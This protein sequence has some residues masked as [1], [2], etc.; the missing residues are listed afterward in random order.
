M[1][2]FSFK[3]PTEIIFG[4][5]AEERVAEKIR[6]YGGSRVFIIYGGGSVIDSAK[7]VAHGL[8]NPGTDIWD[9]WS[10]KEKLKQTTPLA[11]VVTMAAA[12]SEMSDSAVLTNEETGAK[13]G[14]NSEL[15]RPALAFL[16]PELTFTLPKKQL[17]CGISDILMHTLERYFTSVKE[18]NELTDLFAEVLEA[19]Q[20]MPD[21]D[22]LD[23]ANG[24]A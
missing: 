17:A 16:N 8:A 7:G 15:N 18:A 20:S 23:A 9:F 6:A 1:Q 13:A 11:T 24:I 10:G 5:G 22:E 3:C 21:P 19:M 12:G 4:R 2:S 14:L